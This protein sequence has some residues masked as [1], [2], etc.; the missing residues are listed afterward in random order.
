MTTKKKIITLTVTAFI[1]SIG[2][3][4]VWA[5]AWTLYIIFHP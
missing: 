1:A 5:M 3:A 2:I 4:F